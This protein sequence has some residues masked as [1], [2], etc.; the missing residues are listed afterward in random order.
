MEKHNNNHSSS[1]SPGYHGVLF[2][3]RILDCLKSCEGT[4]LE[5][6]TIPTIPSIFGLSTH[7]ISPTIV[8]EISRDFPTFHYLLGNKNPLLITSQDILHSETV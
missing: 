7:H 3:V 6:E 2:N 4:V 8:P 5:G 1:T